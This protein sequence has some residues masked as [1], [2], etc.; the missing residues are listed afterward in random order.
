VPYYLN[1][2]DGHAV[3][4]TCPY[5]TVGQLATSSAMRILKLTPEQRLINSYLRL[6]TEGLLDRI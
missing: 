5:K 4:L 3:I 6:L 1:P 2:I